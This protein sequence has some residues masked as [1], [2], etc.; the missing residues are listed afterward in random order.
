M[1]LERIQMPGIAKGTRVIHN[2]HDGDVFEVMGEFTERDIFGTNE[3]L[4]RE[5]FFLVSVN[6]RGRHLFA[7]AHE[8]RR[9][10]MGG[11]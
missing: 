7:S 9:V 3:G 10:P 2:Q 6:N 5:G 1:R 11:A 8:L 4:H